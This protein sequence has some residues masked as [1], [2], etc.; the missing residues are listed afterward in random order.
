MNRIILYFSFLFLI[1]LLGSCFEKD[2]AVPP[3]PGHVTTI[4]NNIEYYQSYFDFETGVTVAN[5]SIDSWQLGF[6]A[7]DSAWHIVVNS[8]DHWFIWNSHQPDMEAELNPPTIAQW[9]YD[10]QSCF[11]D[12]TSTG[13]WTYIAD[14]NRKYS[15]DVYVLA[16]SIDGNYLQQ[17]RIR[18]LSVESGSYRFFYHDEDTGLSDTVLITKNDSVN[19]VYYNFVTHQQTALEP[20]DTSYDLLF[21]SYYDL[22]TEFGITIPYLVRGVL[23]NRLSTSAALDSVN[24][25]DQIHYGMLSDY[26]FSTQRDFIG[27]LWKEVNVDVNSGSADY[28]VR[29]NYTYIIRTQAGK[30]SKMHFLS[31]SLNGISGFPRFETRELIPG[32]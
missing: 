30:Y 25:Y 32:P 19:F 27:Y 17:K 1:I 29:D 6:E 21:T 7:G 5:N 22:A 10:I 26:H 13:N 23:L 16:K 3:Y 2:K 18:F 8:G 4:E 28:T 31:Y 20:N 12:S 24:G 11:P 14:G 9:P 15:N